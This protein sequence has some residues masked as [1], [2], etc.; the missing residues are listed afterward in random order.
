MYDVEITS[1]L[2]FDYESFEDFIIRKPDITQWSCYE[3]MYSDSK[4]F[5]RTV[6]TYCSCT[7]YVPYGLD[8]TVTHLVRD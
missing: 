4:K 6:L 7:R 3:Y 1:T 5:E 2:N 8:H